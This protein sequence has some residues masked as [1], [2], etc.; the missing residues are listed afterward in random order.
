MSAIICPDEE[1][2]FFLTY[3]SNERDISIEFSGRN[4]PQREIAR[5]DIGKF[6]EMVKEFARFYLSLQYEH[7][8]D[9]LGST[10]PQKAE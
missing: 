6:D 3:D 2:M 10:N 7:K 1:S 8:G 4:F 9:D 5:L